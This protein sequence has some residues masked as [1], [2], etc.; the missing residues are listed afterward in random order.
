MKKKEKEARK[1]C[2]ESLIKQLV[3][4]AILSGASGKEDKEVKIL[5]AEVYRRLGLEDYLYFGELTSLVT[6]KT[7]SKILTQTIFILSQNIFLFP[8]G[9]QQI[10]IKKTSGNKIKIIF[11]GPEVELHSLQKRLKQAGLPIGIVNW[12]KI[13]KY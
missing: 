1:L 11:K 5:E 13:K 4:G 12:R 7:A 6:E 9:L 2:N 3:G 8:H 10:S